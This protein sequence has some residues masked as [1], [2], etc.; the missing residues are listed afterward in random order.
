M[1]ATCAVCGEPCTHQQWACWSESSRPSP[2]QFV[3]SER[4]LKRHDR[5]NW[6]AGDTYH[7]KQVPCA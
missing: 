3:C 5:M 1:T 7:V 6:S 4:C 2:V